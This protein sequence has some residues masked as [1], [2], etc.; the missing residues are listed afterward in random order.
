MHS[1]VQGGGREEREGGDSLH[2]SLGSGRRE[3][4]EGGRRFIACIAWFKVP[5]IGLISIRSEAHMHSV[6]NKVYVTSNLN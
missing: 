3:G 2:A 5:S 6:L 1:L 4:G